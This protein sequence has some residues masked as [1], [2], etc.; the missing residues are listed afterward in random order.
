MR[1]N[2][3]YDAFEEEFKVLRRIRNIF[4]AGARI[5]LAV[6]LVDEEVLNLCRERKSFHASWVEH[7]WSRIF[8]A[9]E[10]AQDIVKE[11]GLP[12]TPDGPPDSSETVW[13]ALHTPPFGLQ[14]P[15]D[16]ITH[17]IRVQWYFN[18]A[19]RVTVY[20][21]PKKHGPAGRYTLTSWVAELRRRAA[22]ALGNQLTDL[23]RR[24]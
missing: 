24:V 18:V 12:K 15:V 14:V 20:K 21:L 10:V 22:S 6:E 13:Q 23:E 8:V 4:P 9:D 3:Q 7:P 11:V 19:A 2:S 16:K 5:E 17:V 1:F